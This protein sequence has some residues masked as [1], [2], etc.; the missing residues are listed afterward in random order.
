MLRGSH[1]REWLQMTV[2][3]QLDRAEIE[4]LVRRALTEDLGDSGDITSKRIVRIDQ[5][6]RARIMAKSE[7]IL[8][9]VPIADAVF[10]AVDK[11][12][13]VNWLVSD[14]ADLKPGLE[15]AQLQGR[16]RAI[17]AAERVALNFLQHLSGV[18]TL[19]NQFVQKAS[20]HGVRILCTRKTLP[21]LRAVERYAVTMGGG[22]LHRAGLYDA[23]L[24][25][26][27]H[28]RLSGGISQALLRTKANPNLE[29]E[30]EV[31]DLEELDEAIAAGAD[32]ILLDNAE[33]P[34]I[35]EAVKRT[36]GK[37]FLEVSGGVNLRNIDAIA[38]LKPDAISV[39]RITHSA[40]AVDL[41]LEV[42]PPD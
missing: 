28:E 29:A 19:T 16:A 2:T 27:N 23:I 17:L 12:L 13:D 14:G 36:R 39:G 11:S 26:T 38:K 37:V 41:A 4:K 40:E 3:T 34:T 25:K 10:H 32:R 31:G 9:G 21:G 33:A 1:R 6:C 24:I 7:G 15:V 20:K 30:V 42:L 5:P 8:A 35:A 18:A 22:S